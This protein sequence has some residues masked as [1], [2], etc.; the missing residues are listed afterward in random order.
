MRPHKTRFSV[1]ICVATALALGLTMVAPAF[2]RP[3]LAADAAATKSV[4]KPVKKPVVAKT[5]AGKPNARPAAV[6]AAIRQEVAQQA[7]STTKFP[8]RQTDGFRV[9]GRFVRVEAFHGHG[10]GQMPAV[11]ILHG[12]S[13]LG[14]G[15]L[16]Y[17][18]ATALNE[19][20]I[21]A[22]I[23]HYF[24]GLPARK[25][26]ASPALHDQRERIVTEALNYV[27]ALT[28]VDGSK[29]G[30]YGLSL[31]GFQALS[32]ASRD[33]R[34]AAVVDV[35]GA[36]PSQVAREPIYRMP[37]TL[38]LHG[39]RDRTVPVARAKELA[40]ILDTLGTPYEMKIYHGESHYFR[41]AA[42]E[43]SMREAADFFDRHLKTP[44]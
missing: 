9:D 7:A 12:A 18:Q 22:F 34:V 2:S 44:S 27:E 11:I 42:R 16:F 30:I 37:P 1:S 26:A 20:G 3:A 32:L 31:G 10:E 33:I 28:Y 41:V 8:L 13:G 21:S 24:D 6:K 23:V 38:I 40:Q 36:M 5:E 4:P 14:D 35:I 43:D 39:D 25:N 15:T 29:I 17:P 19:R